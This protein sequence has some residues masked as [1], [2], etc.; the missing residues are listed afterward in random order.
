MKVEP[1]MFTSSGA[2]MAMAPPSNSA[3]FRVNRMLSLKVR[4]PSVV[5]TPPAVC[6][7]APE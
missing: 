3:T 5:Y 6:K 4:F 1:V 7:K 2:I